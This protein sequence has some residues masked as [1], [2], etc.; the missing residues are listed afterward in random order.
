[1]DRRLFIKILFSSLLT[2]FFLFSNEY[3]KKAILKKIPKSEE[4]IASIGMGTWLTFDIGY[5]TKKLKQRAEILKLFFNSGGQVIDSSPMYGSSEKVIG[6]SLKLIDTY[7]NLFAA[8][9]VWTP[10]RWHGKTVRK[11]KKLLG[12]QKFE[13]LQVHNLVNYEE[14]LETLYDLKKWTLKVHWSNYLSWL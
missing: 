11:F 13:L 1:M 5:N 12:V 2:P 4:Y 14:H 8:T 3:N 6:K 10:N 7:K 9:K